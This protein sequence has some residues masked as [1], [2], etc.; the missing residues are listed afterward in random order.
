MTL[1]K[2][3]LLLT[4]ALLAGCYQ[5]GQPEGGST[6]T[7]TTGAL[8]RQWQAEAE[9]LPPETRAR[10]VAARVAGLLPDEALDFCSRR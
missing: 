2:K 6:G 9:S 7:E 4:A 10:Y 8:I 3:L 5:S 1:N